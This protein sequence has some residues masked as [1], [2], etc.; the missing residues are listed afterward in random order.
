LGHTPQPD[1]DLEPGTRA[2][3]RPGG[4]EPEA[5]VALG[6]GTDAGGVAVEGDL[7]RGL[8]HLVGDKALVGVDQVAPA[9]VAR[10]GLGDALVLQDAA[11][12]EDLL[13]RAVAE[14]GHDLQRPGDAVAPP[15][16]APQGVEVP[17]R[18]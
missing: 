2:G 15:P 18:L 14:V 1:L 8:R 6:V 5:V 11:L 4:L 16:V 17:F 13:E 3:E 7:E 12:D 9:R 10:T